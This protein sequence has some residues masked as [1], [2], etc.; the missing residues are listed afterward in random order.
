[1]NRKLKRAR[2]ALDVRIAPLRPTARFVAPP[3]GW[4][5]AIRDAIGMSGA[6]LAHRLGITPQSVA[7]L[8]KSEAAA[9]VRLE[10]L[11]KAAEAL[12]CTLLYVLVPNQPLEE[13]VQQRARQIATYELGGIAHS[14]AL[15]DQSVRED[16]FDL[17]ITEFVEDTLRDRDPLGR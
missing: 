6:Q 14:M 16:N 7:D 9:T 12:D 13:Q 15:E 8:E 5:R 1:M 17:R 4:I 3:K 10:T 11:R 2:M